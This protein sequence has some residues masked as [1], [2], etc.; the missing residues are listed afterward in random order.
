M[1][2]RRHNSTLSVT[3]PDYADPERRKNRVERKRENVQRMKQ[4]RRGWNSTIAPKSAK[5]AKRQ[6][7]CSTLRHQLIAAH[8]PICMVKFSRKYC[9]N[10]PDGLQHKHKK[11]QGGADSRENAGYLCCNVCNA[12][13]EDNP[14]RAYANGWTVKSWE[15]P[16]VKYGKP[17][18]APL[19]QEH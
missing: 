7:A 2:V 13:I 10:T 4:T 9:T 3:L 1:K 11:S 18:N 16:I 17:I 6:R 19:A 12:A 14:D 15:V 5:Q 8:G